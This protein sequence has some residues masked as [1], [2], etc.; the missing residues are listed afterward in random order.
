MRPNISVI[1]LTYRHE[2]YI[3]ECLHGVMEQRGPFDMEIVVSDDASPDGTYTGIQEMA[4]RDSRIRS[5][6]QDKNLGPAK[7]FEFALGQ[8]RGDYIAYCEGDDV[9]VSPEK[10][11]KQLEKLLLYDDTDM[12]YSQYGKMDATGQVVEAK[13]EMSGLDL[14]RLEDL[15]DGHG[16]SMN[17]V[18]MRRSVLAGKFPMSFFSVPNPDVFILAAALSEKPARLVPGVYSMYRMHEGGIW[19]GKSQMEKNLIRYSTLAKVFRS[20][21]GRRPHVMKKIY[22]RLENSLITARRTDPEM[23]DKYWKSLPWIRRISLKFKWLYA[24]RFGHQQSVD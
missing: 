19:S 20:L 2:D 13:A 7:N 23:F 16:P 22:D 24:R 14:F 9:W 4:K 10:L 1:V 18:M 5:F 6:L 8:C 3:R 15:I 12:V 11:A 17:S 21:P